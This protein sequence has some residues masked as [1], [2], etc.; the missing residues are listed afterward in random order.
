MSAHLHH[1]AWMYYNSIVTKDASTGNTS[2]KTTCSKYIFSSVTVIC[3][4]NGDLILF[5][6]PLRISGGLMMGFQ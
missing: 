4:H 3:L 6:V 5:M 1:I 2:E